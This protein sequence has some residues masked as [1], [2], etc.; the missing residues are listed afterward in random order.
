MYTLYNN[1]EQYTGSKYQYFYVLF[2]DIKNQ[3]IG[4]AA[5]K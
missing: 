1:G 2:M 4:H 3:Y 5:K